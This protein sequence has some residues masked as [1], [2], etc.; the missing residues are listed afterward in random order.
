MK[1]STKAIHV[2]QG[3]DPATGAT[4][5]PVYQTSTYTQEAVGVHKGFD[6]SRTVN[7]TRVALEAQLAALEN[8]DYGSAFASGMAATAAVLNLLSAGDHV[9]VTDDLYGGTYRLFSRV[10]TRY[11]LEF[12]YVDMADTGAVRAAI[13]PNT[14]MFW[15]ETPTNPLLKLIDIRAM[16]RLAHHDQGGAHHDE[17]KQSIV[18]VDNTFASPYFQ[19]PL[20][21]GADIVVH[22]TTKYIGGHSDVVGGAALTNNKEYHDVIKFHQ[23]AVGGVP[24]PHDAWLT[25]RGAKTL[26]IRMREHAKNAQA[27]AEFLEAHAEVDRVYYPGLP[28]HPQHELAKRQ[29]TGFGGMVS[30]TLK[31][32]EQRAIDFANRMQYFSLAE[33]LGGVESLICHP[34]RMTH[35]SIPKEER[36]KRGVTDGLLRLSVGI[37]DVDDLI[38]DLRQ[39]LVAVDRKRDRAGVG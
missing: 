11:G 1:F 15:V 24:G 22:S 14:K 10:L 28:S 3:A 35:G 8:A 27:V 6:Y 9:V 19:Q 30:F 16:V 32:P 20:S 33:S 36:E 12:T 17:S 29:M 26:A 38:D 34:A 5:V 25:M 21:L 39:A 18:V 37:E 7:P 2:G 31:G 4:I 23:N 13:K